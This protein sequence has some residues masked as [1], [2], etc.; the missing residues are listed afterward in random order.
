MRLNVPF[1][2]EWVTEN[3]DGWA[4][5]IVP[6]HLAEA[7][8][9]VYV[10]EVRGLPPV[11]DAKFLAKQLG[12]ATPT[13]SAVVIDETRDDHSAK[14]WPVTIVRA[15]VMLR[16]ALVEQ[17][18]AAFYRLLDQFAAVI[19]VGTDPQRWADLAQ[20]LG[21]V[22]LSADLDWSGPPASLA[23]ILGLDASHSI[24]QRPA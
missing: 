6:G 23:E 20:G 16:G 4:R 3:Q 7:D 10:S 8:L 9:L 21:E 5:T 17:R 15:S 22:V 19:V 11:I 18:L 24:F 1:P 2:A 12:V 14:G 13:A